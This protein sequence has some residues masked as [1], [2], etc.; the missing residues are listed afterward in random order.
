[1]LSEL[2]G[3][4]ARHRVES[5]I[6]QK[7]HGI[8]GEKDGHLVSLLDGGASHEEGERGP[9][10]LFRSVGDVD[11]DLRLGAGGCLCMRVGHDG[12]RNDER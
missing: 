7:L 10:C 12:T 1:M 2:A 6:S 3:A 8:P 9:R 4:H 5:G 11:Q